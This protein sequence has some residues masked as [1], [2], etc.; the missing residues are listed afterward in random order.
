[1][2]KEKM[3][4]ASLREI[5]FNAICLH[6]TKEN[7][8]ESQQLHLVCDDLS[9]LLISDLAVSI[10]QMQQLDKEMFKETVFLC[11]AVGGKEVEKTISPAK[12]IA[13]VL[14]LTKG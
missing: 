13:S 5:F 2:R 6:D 10:T 11:S 7:H 4:T 14:Q 3:R 1:M 9:P 12:Q 8:K